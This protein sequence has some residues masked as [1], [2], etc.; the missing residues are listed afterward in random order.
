MKA[1]IKIVIVFFFMSVSLI[2]QKD[3]KGKGKEKVDETIHTTVDQKAAYT[4]GE[5]ALKDFVKKNT[6]MPA[7]LKENKAAL[8][9][10]VKLTIDETGK[11]TEA[12]TDGASA[13]ADCDKE[14][15]RVAKM[16]VGFTPAKLKGKA[17]K[18][19]FVIHVEFLKEP[20]AEDPDASTSRKKKMVWD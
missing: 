19:Y 9:C 13:C 10:P 17:V 20:V 14:A 15:V 16:L 3:K 12:V 8:K 6:A 7:S 5:T 18:S 4:A 2:A 11:L 1:S